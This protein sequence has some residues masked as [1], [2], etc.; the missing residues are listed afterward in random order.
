[1][2][3]N[4]WNFLVIG[5]D[6]IVLE[7]SDYTEVVYGVI[8]LGDA[9]V[10]FGCYGDNETLFQQTITGE[11]REFHTS[12]SSLHHPCHALRYCV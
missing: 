9:G 10:C 3:D 5:S 12:L 1:M 11:V 4:D 7:L 8:C 2:S 6:E